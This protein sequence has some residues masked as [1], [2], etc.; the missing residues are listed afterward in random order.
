MKN[1]SAL[2]SKA[3]QLD[4]QESLAVYRT[5]FFLP[6]KTLYFDGN[7]LGL[8]SKSAE[9]STLDFVTTWKEMGIDGWTKGQHPWFYMAEELGEFMAPL[10][11]AQKNEVIVSNSTTVNLHQLLATFYKPKGKRVKI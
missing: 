5:E 3:L 11:G 7:S 2:Q 10:V 8:L 9:R 6:K 4:Q 1:F